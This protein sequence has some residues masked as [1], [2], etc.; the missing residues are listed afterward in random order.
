MDA[1]PLPPRPNLDQYKKRSKELVAAARSGQAGA[2]RVWAD[3]WLTALTQ[4]LGLTQS[5]GYD[6]LLKQA[7]GALV[8]RT[9]KQIA[10]ASQRFGLADAQ[11]LIAV[12]H[13][14]ENWA[15]FARHV[16][17]PFKGDSRGREFEAAVDAV[18]SGDL[19]T[20][21]G[22]V[23]G[24]P[25][26]IH[27]HSTREHHATLLHYVAANGVEDYRQRTPPNAV[28]IARFL[29]DA[30]A[31]V[32][33]LADT[34]G[35][36]HWQTTMNLLVSSAHPAGAGLM[37]ALVEV[38]LDHG[39]AINGLRDDESPLLTA[40]DFRYLDA[41]ETLVRRGAR[42]DNVT[43]AAA[44]GR[45]DL[46]RAFV[47]DAN[48]VATG[49]PLVAPPWVKLGAE[50]RPLER[51]PTAHIAFALAWA[52][53]FQRQDVAAWLLDAGVSP[54]AKDGYDMTALHW[55]AANGLM[56]LI[57]RLLSLG[58]PLEVENIWGGTVLDS[59]AH[60]AEFQPVTGVDYPAALEMIANA[61][62]D[63]HVLDGYPAESR[64]VT[65]F[66][67]RRRGMVGGK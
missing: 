32:D 45:L 60:F 58:A 52:C 33:G 29:L 15:V 9:H 7:I 27:E 16:E 55:A 18:V 46:V 11:H 51:T 31:K 62:A 63:L 39:A 21:R 41:A 54:A 30:G 42:V 19:K 4:S 37:S 5:P 40:L 64:V 23:G 66:L 57:P 12:V 49:V 36:D 65:A 43:T 44:L 50:R 59:T 14:F 35:H 61:G 38:L 53:K 20:L 3:H 26:I 1:L 6:A 8:D 17:A 28:Q 13:G 25:K 24:R 22:L 48:T 10:G 47:V 34:Y 2:V 67:R 56:D